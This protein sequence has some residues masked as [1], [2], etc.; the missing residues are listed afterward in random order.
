MMS[1]NTDLFLA[2]NAP[3]GMPPP[4]VAAMSALA[5]LP[6]GLVPGLL[7]LL[8]IRRPDRR[9][10]G[11]LAV[12]PA[13]LLGQAVNLLFGAIWF[14]PRPFVA[15]VGRTLLEH[16]PDNSFPSDHTTAMFAFAAA[17][18]ASRA[19]PRIGVAAAIAGLGVGWARIWLGVHDPIDILAG[20]AVGI[21]TGWVARPLTPII[22]RHALPPLERVYGFAV[23]TLRLSPSIFPR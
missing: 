2:L 8:W 16:A 19:V 22:A 21:M 23:T 20:I 10:A 1:W 5:G 15:G 14:E 18:M 17:L 9:R 13:V 7:I 6:V 4:I 11:L 3:P 12:V